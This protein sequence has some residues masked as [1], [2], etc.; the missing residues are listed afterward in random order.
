MPLYIWECQ[1]GCGEIE[2][3]RSFA[4][5]QVPPEHEHPVKRILSTFIG[6]PDI[7]PYVAKAGDM[8]GKVIGSRVEHKRFLKRNRLVELGDA[9]IADTKQMRKTVKPGEVREAMKAAIAQHTVPDL[10]R[11]GLRERHGA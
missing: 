11:G 8:A 10:K 5:Y 4:D 6:I 2:V 9:P 3:Y 7:Q 1:D